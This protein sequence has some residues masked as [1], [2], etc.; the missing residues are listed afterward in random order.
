MA[1][2]VTPTRLVGVSE[3]GRAGAAWIM[4]TT[5]S[6]AVKVIWDHQKD[7]RHQ[8]SKS[9]G[10]QAHRPI[11]QGVGRGHKERVGVAQGR[12]NG[13]VLPME[14]VVEMRILNISAGFDLPLFQNP[15]RPADN[16]DRIP[17]PR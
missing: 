1:R 8:R 15:D 10:G 14:Y 16:A 4:K 7:G 9:A 12:G 11:P 17:I 6:T 3:E 5:P 13:P 2:S